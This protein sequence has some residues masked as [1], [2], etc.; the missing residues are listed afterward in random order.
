MITDVLHS[1]N[2]YIRFCVNHFELSHVMDIALWK[3]YVLLLLLMS[4]F[5]RRG[6]N[7]QCY[8]DNKVVDKERYPWR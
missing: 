5:L 3:C 6:H 8:Q 1:I 7:Y 4:G 2:M